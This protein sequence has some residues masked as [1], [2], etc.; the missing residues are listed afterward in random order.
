MS[1]LNRLEKPKWDLLKVLIYAPPVEEATILVH[2]SF[3]VT[4]EV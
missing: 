2:L 1:Y 4:G 3:F